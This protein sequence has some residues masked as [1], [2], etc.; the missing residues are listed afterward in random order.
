MYG[1][2]G[3][4]WHNSRASLEGN[5]LFNGRKKLEDYNLEGED[6][7][8]YAPAN[9]MPAWL[10]FN[11]RG[12]YRFGKYL[13]LQAGIDNIMDLQ[14]RNFASGINAPGRNFWLTLRT[15]W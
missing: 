2:A 13:S 12:S 3:A 9:G 7:L 15:A 1:R 11:M 8:Q 10:T 5:V 6:N 14:Y 4:R